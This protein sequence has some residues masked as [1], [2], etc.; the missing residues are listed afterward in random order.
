MP[1][2]RGSSSSVAYTLG[3]G[4]PPPAVK[5]VLIAMIGIFLAQYV[6]DFVAFGEYGNVDNAVIWWL[7]MTPA[8]VVRGFVWQL[9]SYMF[10]RAGFMHLIFNMLAVWMFGVDLE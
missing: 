6:L 2:V 5:L 4:A 3:P 10:L 8:L 1:P 9:A 7:G